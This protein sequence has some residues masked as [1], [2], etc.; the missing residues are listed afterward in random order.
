MAVPLGDDA[1]RAW[2][3]ER[4]AG[5]TLA[6][7]S[8]ACAVAAVARAR[9]LVAGDTVRVVM[10]GGEVTVRFEADG[11]HLRG[12]AVV[13]YGGAVRGDVWEGWG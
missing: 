5:E 4:G 6:S 10:E 13:V 2:I 8:S 11:V 7:G 12:E 9:G 1:V 3:W